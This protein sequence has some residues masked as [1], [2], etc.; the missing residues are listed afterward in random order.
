[1]RSLIWLILIATAA[2]VAATLL[3]RNDALVS[4]FYGEW[5]VD[6]SLNLFIVEIG[7]AHV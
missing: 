6:V 3:G 4:I 5:R 1:M 2:V 7:R